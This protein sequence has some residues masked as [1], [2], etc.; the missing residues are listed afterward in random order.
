[1]KNVKFFDSFLKRRTPFEK[2]KLF[3]GLANTCAY[4]I[5]G[6]KKEHL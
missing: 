1:M 5:Y 3:D 2:L 6:L 4:G